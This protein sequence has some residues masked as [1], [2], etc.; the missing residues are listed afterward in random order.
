VDQTRHPPLRPRPRGLDPKWIT[1]W[2]DN[3]K[4]FVWHKTA[5]Q[6]LDSLAAYCQRIDDSGH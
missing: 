3:T 5:D 6:I 2:N 4:P 1:D